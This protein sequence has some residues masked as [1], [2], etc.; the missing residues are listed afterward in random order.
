MGSH[1]FFRAI[2]DYNYTTIQTSHLP[3]D[4]PT[5]VGMTV[6]VVIEVTFTDV[7]DVIIMEATDVVVVVDDIIVME[8]MMLLYWLVQWMLL[9]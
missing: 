8:L 6:D 1:F 5:Q 2:S 4:P 9:W 3:E 7:D